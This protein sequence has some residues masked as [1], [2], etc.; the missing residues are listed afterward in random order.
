M[1]GEVL[2]ES[3]RVHT[4][5]EGGGG[6]GQNLGF[7][8]CTYFMDALFHRVSHKRVPFYQ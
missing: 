8:L 1:Q 7:L 5:A 2:L 6:G 3:V 4:G